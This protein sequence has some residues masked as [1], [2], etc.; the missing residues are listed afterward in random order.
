MSKYTLQTKSAV[1]YIAS[2]A[3]ST[4]SNDDNNAQKYDRFHLIMQNLQ[5]YLEIV[6]DEQICCSSAVLQKLYV[7]LIRAKKIMNKIIGDGFE[8]C[9]FVTA[10]EQVFDC[11]D[12][13]KI[14][15]LHTTQVEFFVHYVNDSMERLRL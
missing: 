15:T 13:K 3:T 2:T 12:A 6:A 5:R 9:A 1:P 4:A 10:G 8:M 11:I 7:T 14:S